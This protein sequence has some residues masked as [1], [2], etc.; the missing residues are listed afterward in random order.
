MEFDLFS[1]NK[2]PFESALEELK[3]LANDSFLQKNLKLQIMSCINILENEAEDISIRINKI[4]DI[5]DE[6]CDDTNIESFSRTRLYNVAQLLE[7]V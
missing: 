5:L 4:S 3:D 2:D 7:Q 1:D 6:I